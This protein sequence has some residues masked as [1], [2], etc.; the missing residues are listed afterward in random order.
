M[1][2]LSF[3]VPFL[4]ICIPTYN[5]CTKVYTLVT[6]IL[7][8]EKDDIEILVLDNCSTEDLSLLNTIN[9]KRFILHKNTH[10]IGGPINHIK[11]LTLAKGKYAVLC[12]DK[13]YIDYKG[14]PALIK[15]L[16]NNDVLFGYCKL[17][18]QEAIPDIIYDKG[19]ASIYNMAFLSA[20]PTGKFYQTVFFNKLDITKQIIR[21]EKPF[22]FYP[23]LINASMALMGKSKIINS[24]AFYCETKD[25]C[26]GNRSLTYNNENVFFSPKKRLNEL[27]VYLCTVF[28]LNLSENELLKIVNN[29]YK[30][31]LVSAT[32][33]YK[34][35]LADEAICAH[36]G[37]ESRTI[38]I[39]ELLKNYSLFSSGFYK[40][41]LPISNPKKLAI[42]LSGSFHFTSILA[43]IFI[44]KIFNARY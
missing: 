36:Y 41:E 33:G 13:D 14:I 16:S 44:K 3:Y 29:L 20:H 8:Y 39:K 24:P 6:E 10:N 21:D 26:A 37:I 25:E 19:F 40:K 23:D 9:D 7:K 17:D 11:A 12:L 4:S 38:G 22:D 32:F 28:N 18:I 35:I 43:S 27:F 5:R 2:Q 1:D 15:A 30:K 31:K 42:Y 34:N